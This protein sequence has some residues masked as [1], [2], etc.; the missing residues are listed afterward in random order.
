MV[1]HIKSTL[2]HHNSLLP[3][4]QHMNIHPLPIDHA[5]SGPEFK[6]KNT[7]TPTTRTPTTRTH[8]HKH[9][10]PTTHGN[11]KNATSF[12]RPPLPLLS[13]FLAYHTKRA[14]RTTNTNKATILPERSTASHDRVFSS[15]LLC[16]HGSPR[17]SVSNSLAKGHNTT[18]MSV[19]KEGRAR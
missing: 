19:L 8:A 16:V 12:G 2:L 1:Y 5:H 4:A 10:I 3:G 9:I 11:H 6:R 14:A 18:N 15:S 7:R 13:C 17:K